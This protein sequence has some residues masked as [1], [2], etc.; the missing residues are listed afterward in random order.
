MI[1]V[2]KE[3]EPFNNETIYFQETVKNWRRKKKTKERYKHSDNRPIITGEKIIV[4]NSV[5]INIHPLLGQGR[6]NG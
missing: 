4:L 2:L 1:K 5:P 6:Q 3:L